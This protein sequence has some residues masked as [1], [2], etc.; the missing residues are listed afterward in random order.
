MSGRTGM[1]KGD[2]LREAKIRYFMCGLAVAI[3]GLGMYSYYVRELLASLALS[4]W[5]LCPGADWIGRISCVVGERASG[6]LGAARVAKHDGVLPPDDL[7]VRKVLSGKSSLQ[8]RPASLSRHPGEF[9]ARI[10]FAPRTCVFENVNV[11]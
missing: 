8:F 4:A 1:R 5:V 2:S 11:R 9:L 7:G 10:E 6:N 3:V